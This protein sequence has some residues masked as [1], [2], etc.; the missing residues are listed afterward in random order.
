[1]FLFSLVNFL[2]PLSFS[3][4][5]TDVL[6][7]RHKFILLDEGGEEEKTAGILVYFTGL[8]GSFEVLFELPSERGGCGQML[9]TVFPCNVIVQILRKG[10]CSYYFY[11]CHWK[12]F[13]CYT[14]N[15]E[16][17]NGTELNIIYF[18]A[19]YYNYSN[20]IKLHEY[21]MQIKLSRTIPKRIALEHR[22]AWFWNSYKDHCFMNS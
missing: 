12:F 20:V 11:F 10:L 2:S 5:K 13:K 21:S 15:P 17:L 6:I 4:R 9:L 18:K 14:K 8:L 7:F 3:L 22:I 19:Q 16:N 1:M